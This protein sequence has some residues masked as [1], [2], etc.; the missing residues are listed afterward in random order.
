LRNQKI[1]QMKRTSYRLI[2]LCLAA[3]ALYIAGWF[4]IIF[5]ESPCKI[6]KTVSIYVWPDDTQATVLEKL[7]KTGKIKH[8]GKLI[9]LLNYLKYKDNIHP[10]RYDIKP[11]MSNYK[12]ARNLRSGLQTPVK[13]TFNNIRTVE[14]LAGRFSKQLM[15]DSVSILKCFQKNEWRDSMKLTSKNYMCIFIPNTYEVYWNTTTDKLL[16]LLRRE[17]KKFWNNIRMSKANKLGLTQTEVSTLASIVEE[18]T[19][20]SDEMPKVA[21]LY[22]NRLRINMPL[23]ADPTVKF[24]VGDFT[25]KRILKEQTTISSPYNTYKNIGL[26]PGPIRI[27]SI[28]AIDAVLNA[29]HHSYIYMCAKDDFSGYHAFATTLAQHN[30]NAEAYHKALNKNGIME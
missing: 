28:T 10:G 30:A 21:G 7:M 1:D 27:P 23:Q 5:I 8:P 29:T 6:E 16:T 11:G 24:T 9:S 18:E 26:P 2:K 14:D 20:K 3:V 19:N 17:Y 13:L 22:L 12:I 4:F 15:V 25:I